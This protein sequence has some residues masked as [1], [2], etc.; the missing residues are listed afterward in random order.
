MSKGFFIIVIGLLLTGCNISDKK[1]KPDRKVSSKAPV[2]TVVGQL[3]K[4]GF[5]DI[6][7]PAYLDSARQY[8]IN[9]YKN[10]DYFDSYTYPDSIRYVDYRFY[11]V[12]AEELF[13]VGGLT[14]YLDLVKPT[15]E[16]SG[17]KLKYANEKNMEKD[18]YWKHTIELNGKE[19][20]AFEGS[21]DKK[22]QWDIAYINFIEMLNDQLKLQGSNEQFYPVRSGNDGIMV[23][24]TPG[25]FDIV[26]KY[27]PNDKDRP[28]TVADW[29]RSY[30]KA[31][32]AGQRNDEL[33]T[34]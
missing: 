29:K 32:F 3:I 23:M 34:L 14:E 22:G 28:K 7:D 5:F 1:G 25:Q 21:L 6:T 16:R 24:L 30:G 20:I 15:F 31:V 9:A 13:K 8:L 26:K 12:D 2:D 11:F 33:K 10:Q 27:Y 4:A 19:Y 18:N 17:L